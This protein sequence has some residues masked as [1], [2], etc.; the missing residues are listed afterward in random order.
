[1]RRIV[2][3]LYSLGPA[4]RQVIAGPYLS[5]RLSHPKPKLPRNRQ[6]KA[7][8]DQILPSWFGRLMGAYWPLNEHLLKT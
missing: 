8:V 2:S 6:A 7:K 1:M 3:L 4:Y 5:N